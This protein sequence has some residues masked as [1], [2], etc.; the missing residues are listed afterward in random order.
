MKGEE[1]RL[2]SI[3]REKILSLSADE[4]NNS[5]N[6]SVVGISRALAFLNLRCGITKVEDISFKLIVVVLAYYFID[7][8]IWLSEKNLN[9]LESWYWVTVFSGRYTYRQNEHC[10]EDIKNLET[11][12][13]SDKNKFKHLVPE[14]LD[15]KGCNK[16]IL[17]RKNFDESEEVES[18]SIRNIMLQFILSRSPYDFHSENDTRLYPWEIARNSQRLEIHHVIPLTGATKIEQSTKEIRKN[19]KSQLNSMLNMT[20]IS[21]AANQSIK[22]RSASDYLKQLVAETVN[23][24]L[25]SYDSISETTGDNCEKF[26]ASRYEKLKSAILDRITQLW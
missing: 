7:D 13:T 18:S 23:S 26:L 11:F 8:K 12:I 5:T 24:H 3:K 25:I 9:K 15:F 1:I 22:D 16:D 19:I 2:E 17:L 10:I 21:R 14:I 4:I 6:S 20:F